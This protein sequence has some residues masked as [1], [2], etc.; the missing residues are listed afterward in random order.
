MFPKVRTGGGHEHPS[1]RVL[2][3]LPIARHKPSMSVVGYMTRKE[4]GKGVMLFWGFV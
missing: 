1:R 4:I 2:R 3:F